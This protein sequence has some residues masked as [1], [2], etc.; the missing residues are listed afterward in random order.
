[1]LVALDISQSSLMSKFTL[2]SYNMNGLYNGLEFAA[3]LLKECD[4]LF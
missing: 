1:M 3:E 4:I 2:H